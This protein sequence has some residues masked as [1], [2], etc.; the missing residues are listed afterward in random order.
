MKCYYHKIDLDGKCSAAIVKRKYFDCE[1][2]GVDYL[3]RPDF[4]KFESKERIFVVDF[5]FIPTDMDEIYSTV[6]LTWI[7]HHES[8]LNNAY[9]GKYKDCAGK[10][11]IGKAGCELTWEYLFPDVAMPKAVRLLG[12]YDVWDKS[13][14]ELWEKEILP[15]QYGMR[16]ARCFPE[17]N[18]WE[19]VLQ[20]S[21]YSERWV[22]DL[23]ESGRAILDYEK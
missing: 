8:A 22:D 10:R 12:R 14:V 6:F 2:I 5:S 17:D 20:N 3:D 23:L 15:F 7:D 13:D 1:L 4:D 21:G 19:I 16:T 11:K 9:L 18:V